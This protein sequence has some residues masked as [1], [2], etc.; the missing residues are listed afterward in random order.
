[1]NSDKGRRSKEYCSGSHKTPDDPILPLNS[2]LPS[3]SDTSP[4]IILAPLFFASDNIY[5]YYLL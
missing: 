2:T 5:Y 4:K 3:L 1:M